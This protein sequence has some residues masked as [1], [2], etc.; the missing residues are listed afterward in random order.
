MGGTVVELNADT[1]SEPG[2]SDPRAELGVV[3]QFRLASQSNRTG[4]E[5]G[6]G[7][8]TGTLLSPV[9]RTRGRRQILF[10]LVAGA[11]FC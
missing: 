2:A 11:A 5:T 8:Q 6:S 3:A 9:Q 10:A 7:I 4:G 1:R